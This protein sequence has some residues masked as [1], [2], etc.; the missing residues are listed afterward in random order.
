MKE[1]KPVE[2]LDRCTPFA[3]DKDQ[4]KTPV[5]AEA[6]KIPLETPKDSAEQNNQNEK[7][8]A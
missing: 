2:I 5:K 8:E 1:E 4:D 6:M 7:E 3:E